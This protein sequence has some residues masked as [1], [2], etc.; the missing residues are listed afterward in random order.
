[1]H[2]GE[3]VVSLF[4]IAGM[5][6]DPLPDGLIHVGGLADDPHEDDEQRPT[7]RL[8]HGVEVVGFSRLSSE[9]VNGWLIC[10]ISCRGDR[11]RK[12]RA[13]KFAVAFKELTEI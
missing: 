11:R 1:M 2:A 8:F 13:M 10:R 3:I 6:L 12:A 4:R 5:V 9:I 7:S